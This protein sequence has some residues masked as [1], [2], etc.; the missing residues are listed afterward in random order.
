[1]GDDYL[2]KPISIGGSL[3]APGK[4]NNEPNWLM[5]KFLFWFLFFQLHRERR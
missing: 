4:I 5:S 1:M 2:S 3:G